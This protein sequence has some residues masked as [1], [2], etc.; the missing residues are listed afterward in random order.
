M[1]RSNKSLTL[2]LIA[3]IVAS[4]LLFIQLA[5]AQST[6]TVTDFTLQ[7]VDNSYDTPPTT[8]STKD[9]YTGEVTTQTHP[10]S[11]IENK[12][13][14][15]TIRNPSGATYYNFRWKGYYDDVW[16]YY[17]FSPPSG[18]NTYGLWDTFSVPFPASTSTYTVLSLYFLQ[19]ASITT[20]GKIDIQVQV[21][22]G[23]FRAEPYVHAGWVGG[24]T[25]DFYFE[26]QAGDWSST[27]TVTYGKASPSPTVPEF[28]TIAI[29]PLFAVIPLIAAII[30]RKKAAKTALA[31]L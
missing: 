24:P 28:P 22:Y 19:Q 20:G 14:I 30:M 16:H 9:P 4:S 23:D 29:L 10:G 2:L 27:Q 25:Y 17:P 5:S 8:T 26:G 18:N 15:A 6:P 31:V 1:K 11:H 21:L 13:V 7:Y 3:A 12:T